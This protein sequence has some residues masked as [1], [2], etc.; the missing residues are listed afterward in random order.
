MTT[1]SAKPPLPH[2]RR[3]RVM[4]GSVYLTLPSEWDLPA[5]E[6]YLVNP[7]EED[8]SIKLVPTRQ[9]S[10]ASHTEAA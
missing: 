7:P 9:H 2:Y 3:L 1:I 10:L 5:Y 8:G 6:E 4:H